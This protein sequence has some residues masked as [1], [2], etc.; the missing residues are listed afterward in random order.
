MPIFRCARVFTVL[1]MVLVCFSACAQEVR[2][3][4]VSNLDAQSSPAVANSS[5]DER[6]NLFEDARDRVFYPGDTEHLKPLGKKL[7]GNLLLDQKEIWTSPF[8]MHKKNAK[9]WIGFGAVTAVLVAADH[10]TSTQHAVVDRVAQVL[11][12][13]RYRSV[14][15]TI[16]ICLRNER[17]VFCHR[18][19]L[20]S[21]SLP[22]S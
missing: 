20:S 18:W 14:V 19:R 13:P 1:T 21:R 4:C 6:V 2:N 5:P 10:H 12:A 3:P 16:N 7:M 22:G 15:W 9:W 11:L 17:A 8:H